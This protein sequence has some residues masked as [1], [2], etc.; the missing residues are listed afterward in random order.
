MKRRGFLKMLAIA[1]IAAPATVKALA[2][3]SR[4]A[5]LVA[6]LPR[7]DAEPFFGRTT[8]WFEITRIYPPRMM[9]FASDHGGN[10]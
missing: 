10:T 4:A 5:G 1:P 8:E 7:D 3:Q 6:W 9:T 2:T